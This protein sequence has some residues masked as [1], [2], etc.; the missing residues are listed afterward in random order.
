M[1]V[2]GRSFGAGSGGLGAVGN[3]EEAGSATGGGSGSSA[4]R[5]IGGL[6]LDSSFGRG[7]GSGG[8]GKGVPGSASVRL[9]FDAHQALIWDFP[10][11][12]L[13]LAALLEIL[14]EENRA[15]GIGDED[16]GSRQ[17]DIAG[18]ILHLNAA[19]E[20]SGVPRHPEFSV[21]RW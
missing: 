9:F 10:A 16:A 7:L 3:G 8:R 14:F 15:S 13:V 12:M 6:G 17:K 2:V 1:E 18:A 4:A 20:K 5:L 11:E 19:P 21:G